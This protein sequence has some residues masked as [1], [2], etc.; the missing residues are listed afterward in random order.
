MKM[1]KLRALGKTVYYD[2]RSTFF[3]LGEFGQGEIQSFPPIPPIE[4]L[5]A[6]S[7]PTAYTFC[8]DVSDSCN[9]RCDYCF[10][11]TKTGK[12]IDAAT[13]IAY[14]EV[15]FH[16]YDSGEKYFV[17]MSGKG[18][19][20]LALKTVLEIARWC[21]RK[22][23]E[24]RKEVLPQFVCNGTLLS[25]LVAEVLQNEGILFGVSLDGNREVHDSHRRDASGRPTFDA[26]INVVKSIRFRDYVGCA[27][28]LTKDVFPLVEAIDSL[29]PLFK[30]ISFRPARGAYSFDE[31]SGKL[32]ADQYE[33]L[34]QRLLGDIRR[35]DASVFLALMNGEDYFG[36]YLVR[37]VGFKR[38]ITRCDASISRFALDIDGNIYPCPACCDASIVAGSFSSNGLVEAF[39]LETQ[40]VRCLGCGF[41]Y[42]CGGE[43]SVNIMNGFRTAEVLCRFRRKLITIAMVLTET[44]RQEN[45]NMHGRLERFCEEKCRRLRTD[46]E[47]E[48]YMA[49]YPGLSF[50]QAKKLFDEKN[51]RY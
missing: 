7:K 47:L 46:T 22:Q 17:D 34:G 12:T 48:K 50:T 11:K 21:R 44:M 33:L 14:L 45:P 49:S 8:V 20:L 36:R 38:T 29:L 39:S 40:A 19:P 30:T 25:P 37:A 35:D 18:E 4:E 51:K 3:S 1:L 16:K 2:E 28:T 31:T 5:I 41:K 9:L 15:M 32:W 10:N 24:I 42:F 43:C 27:A 23:D 6:A 13:A 26:I